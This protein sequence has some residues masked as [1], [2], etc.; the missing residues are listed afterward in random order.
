[1]AKRPYH[2]LDELSEEIFKHVQNMAQ[3]SA[4]TL[5]GKVPVGTTRL[6]RMEKLYQFMNMSPEQRSQ[7]ALRDPN[8]AATMEGELIRQ[9]GPAGAA[10][11]PYLV[12]YSQGLAGMPLAS[13]GYD[14][15]FA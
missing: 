2:W 13:G 6:T 1:M 9:M 5:E 4:T 11:L 10:L 8:R 7:L 15:E 3:F 12:P 14:D